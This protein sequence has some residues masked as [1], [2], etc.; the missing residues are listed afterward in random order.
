MTTTKENLNQSVPLEAQFKSLLANFKAQ[1]RYIDGLE[2]KIKDLTLK[3]EHKNAKI[4]KLQ[5]ELSG[6]KILRDLGIKDKDGLCRAIIDNTVKRRNMQK[7]IEN[8]A[9]KHKK[10]DVGFDELKELLDSFNADLDVT[11]EMKEHVGF[12]KSLFK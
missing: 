7:A 4:R 8:F 6:Y 9:K 10:K 11:P 5:E 2:L 12:F 3:V 1:N